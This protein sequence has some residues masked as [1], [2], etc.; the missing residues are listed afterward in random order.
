MFKLKEDIGES[1]DRINFIYKNQKILTECIKDFKGF[2]IFKEKLGPYQKGKSYKLKFFLAIPLIKNNIL[3]IAPED[4]FDN[5][6]AQRYAIS[7]RDDLKL[8]ELES[9][10][11][12][13]KIKEFKLFMKKAVNIGEKPKTDLDRFNSY[14][15]NIIDSRLLKLLRLSTTELS[16]SD[17]QRLTNS[18]KILISNISELINI[19]RNYY[20]NQ[21]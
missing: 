1:L 12:L 3:K 19:W 8:K 14:N 5:R 10:Y 18:E 16:P 4:K 6:D 2:T 15:A 11:F 21:N 7:E 17:E 9:K 20:L 13:N